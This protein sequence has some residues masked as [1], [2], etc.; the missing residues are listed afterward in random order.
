MCWNSS[1]GTSDYWRITAK[2]VDRM[3]T[4]RFLFD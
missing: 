3:E 1:P 4:I 2:Q